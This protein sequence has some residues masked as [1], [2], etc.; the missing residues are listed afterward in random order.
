M[1]HA[2]GFFGE[3]NSFRSSFRVRIKLPTFCVLI[4]VSQYKIKCYHK[5]FK[6]IVLGVGVGGGG[7]YRLN[8][9]GLPVK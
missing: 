6:W 3:D 1:N 5:Y 2:M 7:G 4:I 8:K 9:L